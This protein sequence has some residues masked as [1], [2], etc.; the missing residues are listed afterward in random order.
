M[1]LGSNKS[2]TFF[3]DESR[4]SYSPTKKRL[5]TSRETI[6]CYRWR[7]R[8][9]QEY[10]TRSIAERAPCQWHRECR[11]VAYGSCKVNT[12][13]LAGANI[14][15]DGFHYPKAALCTFDD[16]EFAF[17]RRGAPFTFDVDA[18]R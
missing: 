8:I 10:H 1:R 14:K 13:Y 17:R 6:D 12:P 15:Q 2:L 18:L 3:T 11:C 9:W 5:E 16:P 7:A 4:H